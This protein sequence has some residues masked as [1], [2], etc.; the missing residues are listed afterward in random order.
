MIT[1]MPKDPVAAV[2]AMLAEIEER[3]QVRVCLAVESGSR[4]WGFPSADSDYDVRF[5]YV[6]HPDWYLSIEDGRDVIE[7]PLTDMVDLSGWDI[8]KAL[9][10]FRKSNPP[11]LEWLQCPIVYVERSAFARTLRGLLPSFFSSEAS[12]YHYL[13]MARGNSRE[14]L[15]GEVVWRKKYLYVL[16]PLLAMRWIEGGRGPVPI[17][18]SRLCEATVIDGDLRRA[19]DELVAA[20]VAGNEQD[21]GPRIQLISEFIHQ[22]LAR[23]EARDAN[24]RDS[25]PPKAELD[26]VFRS[27]LEETWAHR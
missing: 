5:V 15:Q 9:K 24:R 17:E 1:A 16:R 26:R 20:K 19:I 14:Y 12:F 25:A 22:E 18:F 10:L 21:E 23:S 8:R 2:L 11:L 13:H 27:T 6:H 3:D 4:A 7:Q